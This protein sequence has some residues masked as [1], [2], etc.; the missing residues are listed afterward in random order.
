MH[1]MALA[2]G[3]LD[4]ALSNAAGAR[5]TKIQLLVGT[6][7]AVEPESLRFC[8]QALSQDTPAAGAALAIE[9]VPLT[10]RCRRC[11]RQFEV[12]H[13]RFLCPACGADDV[14]VVSGRELKVAYL[15]VE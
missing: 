14:A 8:F 4:I 11:G 10:A 3:V 2:Q 6:M 5:I 7:T 15:E 9:M 13:Y 1:E 12:E